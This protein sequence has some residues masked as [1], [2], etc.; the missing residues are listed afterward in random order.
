MI[1]VATLVVATSDE[2]F[3]EFIHAFVAV[4]MLISYTIIYSIIHSSLE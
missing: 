1:V 3:V 2:V 4:T